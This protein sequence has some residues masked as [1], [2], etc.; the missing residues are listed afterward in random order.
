MVDVDLATRL[1]LLPNIKPGTLEEIIQKLPDVLTKM[2]SMIETHQRF[3]AHEVEIK[4]IGSLGISFNEWLKFQPSEPN[5]EEK[6]LMY[7]L[8]QEPLSLS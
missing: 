5:N 8:P 4:A 3:A 2:E 7:I 6:N 1:F